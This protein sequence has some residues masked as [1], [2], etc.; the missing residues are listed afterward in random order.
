ML[1]AELRGVLLKVLF[2][3]RNNADGGVPISDLNVRDCAAGRPEI[4]ASCQQLADAGMINWEPLTGEREGFFIG[5]AWITGHGVDVVTGSREPGIEVIFPRPAQM[6]PPGHSQ[7]PLSVMPDTNVLIHGKALTEL[8]WGEFKRPVVEVVLVPPTI[9][10]LDKLKN[11]SGR[12]N[13][14]ARQISSELRK[15]QG[16]DPVPLTVKGKNVE[17]TKRIVTEAVHKPLHPTLSLNHADQALINY[18]LHL[19]AQGHDIILL[20][21]D[22]ICS[23]T[24]KEAGLPAKLLPDE[25]RRDPE[26]DERAK[27][28]AKLKA[29]NSRLKAAEPQVSLQWCDEGGK[30]LTRLEISQAYWPALT[31]DQIEQLMGEIDGLCPCATSFEPQSDKTLRQ[32]SAVADALKRATIVRREQWNSP[33][34]QDI[35]RYKLIDHP[36]WRENMRA[37]LEG[38]HEQLDAR[39]RRPVVE[40]RA[41]NDGTRPATDV[42]LSF[43]VKGDLSVRNNVSAG[44]EAAVESSAFLLPLPPEPPR[45]TMESLPHWS[46]QVLETYKEPKLPEPD[47]LF[48]K[49]DRAV[50]RL[51]DAFYWRESKTDWRKRQDVE[52]HAWRH[53]Q[54]PQRFAISLSPDERRNSSGAV[55]VTAHA[56]NLSIPIVARLPVAFTFYAEETFEEVNAMVVLLAKY[57]RQNGRL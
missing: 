35:N 34:E 41:T 14:I 33:S 9:R 6:L 12:P 24:A 11:Q 40:I 44:E 46:F 42:L 51:P 49:P 30:P 8:P 54:E 7:R 1:D 39:S 18:G 5:K 28:I 10:E 2:D 45:G 37:I 19:Q 32:F 4:T 22:Y 43:V 36:Q 53:G 52:C 56:A 47:V 50:G 57:A 25:W 13:R 26:E 16:P 17:V 27:E 21:D 55:K 15:N 23:V 20:T 48:R 29:E 38:I 3:H 31:S